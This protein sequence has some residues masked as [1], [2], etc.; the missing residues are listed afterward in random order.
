MK[1]KSSKVSC[2]VFSLCRAFFHILVVL[3][4][5]YLVPLQ[6]HIETAHETVLSKVTTDL[7]IGTFALDWSR[8]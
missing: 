7:G 5:I 3:C 2:L 1:K 8:V 4:K 6:S